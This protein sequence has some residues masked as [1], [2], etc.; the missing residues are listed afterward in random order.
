MCKSCLC[1]PDK[2]EYTRKTFE[3]AQANSTNVVHRAKKLHTRAN[4]STLV[5]DVAH[6]R[7][8][9]G[10]RAQWRTLEHTQ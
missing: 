10:T 1:T 9:D 4:L 6:S 5:E 8:L 7:T 2:T 3:H